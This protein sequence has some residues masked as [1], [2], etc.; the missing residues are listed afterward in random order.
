MRALASAL[1]RER[2]RHWR[3]AEDIGDNVALREPLICASNLKI[4]DPDM[5][6]VKDSNLCAYPLVEQ[7]LPLYDWEQ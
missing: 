3:A 7:V 1:A 2:E 5:L 6:P 4:L